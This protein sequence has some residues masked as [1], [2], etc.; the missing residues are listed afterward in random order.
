M[1]QAETP[2]DIFDEV[3]NADRRVCLGNVEFHYF[4]GYYGGA[5]TIMPGVSTRAAIQANHSMMVDPR[6]CTG[7]IKGNPVREDIDDVARFVHIDFIVNVVLDE[8]K[9]IVNAVAGHYTKAHRKAC[10]YLDKMYK[11]KIKKRIDV[12]IVSPGGYP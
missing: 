6:S 5:R 7:V 4:A 2:V 11:I 8:G 1:S 3:V 10:V 12:V 9:N